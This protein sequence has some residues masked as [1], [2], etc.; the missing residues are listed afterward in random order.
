MDMSEMERHLKRLETRMGDF[1]RLSNLLKDELGG[2]RSSM[3]SLLAADR[4]K[5]AALEGHHKA[6]A[7]AS[8]RAELAESR[9]IRAETRAEK[10]EDELFKLQTRVDAITG[11]V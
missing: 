5:G 10:L 11:A 3:G 8:L 1:D 7:S 2:L 9:A 6:Y 4:E